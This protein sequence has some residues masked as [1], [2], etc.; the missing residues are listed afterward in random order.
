VSY[1]HARGPKDERLLD[2]SSIIVWTPRRIDATQSIAE[3]AELRREGDHQKSSLYVASTAASPYSLVRSIFLKPSPLPF[4]GTMKHRRTRQIFACVLTALAVFVSLADP[5]GATTCTQL[6]GSGTGACSLTGV[7]TVTSGSNIDCSGRDL[8]LA[9]SVD[10]RVND[11]SMT[12]KSRDL[13]VTNGAKIRA[14]EVSGGALKVAVTTERDLTLAGRIDAIGSVSGGTIA[15]EVGRNFVVSNYSLTGGIRANGDGSGADGGNISID[16]AGT[17]TIYAPILATGAGAGETFGGQVVLDSVGAITFGLSS[18]IDVSSN[19]GEAGNILVSSEANIA[20][21]GNGM[22]ADGTGMDGDG[23]DISILAATSLSVTG[24]LSVKGGNGQLSSLG[25]GGTL[26]LRAGCG[27]IN[28]NATVDATNSGRIELDA[29]GSVT[30]SSSSLLKTEATNSHG[31]GGT[32]SIRSR[33]ATSSIATSAGSKIRAFGN[34]NGF[35]GRIS[36][37]GCGINISS[38]TTVDAH[39][40]LGGIVQ[41]TASSRGTGGSIQGGSLFVSSGATVSVTGGTGGF[42]GQAQLVLRSPA[43]GTCSNNPLQSCTV[44]SSCG[45]GTCTGENPNTDNVV[46]QFDVAPISINRSTLVECTN[47]CGGL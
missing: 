12:L 1:E 29:D 39:G 41:F 21:D 43:P 34:S 20:I 11:G 7:I 3:S 5:A 40:K 4:G 17:S 8:S 16:V 25:T 10:L 30:L 42:P 13:F 26:A 32:V 45:A 38:G 35:G 24:P 6:C 36:L 2:T 27:G 19:L 37:L 31:S 33:S 14:R 44:N 18:R 23:G 47:S 28:L 15:I 46:S 22:S 9:A